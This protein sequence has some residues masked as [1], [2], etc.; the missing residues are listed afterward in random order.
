ME[1]VAAFSRA[2][3]FLFRGLVGFVISVELGPAE[4]EGADAF[5][6]LHSNSPQRFVTGSSIGPIF[7]IDSSVHRHRIG[8][9]R[10]ERATSWSQTRRS[11]KL[12]YAP[13]FRKGSNMGEQRRNA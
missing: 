4:S 12:S 2:G 3:G 11:T 6:A 7:L 8:A 1:I 9:T 10:F 13:L 5:P